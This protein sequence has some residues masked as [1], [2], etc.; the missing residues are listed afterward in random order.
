VSGTPIYGCSGQVDGYVPCFCD[1]GAWSCDDPG[2]P[3]CAD[4]S[5]P[6]SKC[7]DPQTVDQGV[8]CV[9]EGQQC[10]G[11]PTDCGGQIVYDAFQCTAGTWDD[12]ATTVCDVDASD[13]GGPV[14]AGAADGGGG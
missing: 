4:V 10:P 1:S 8:S 6:P 7:P 5:P 3:E 12:V 2:P 14:D 13:G 11:R 9:S